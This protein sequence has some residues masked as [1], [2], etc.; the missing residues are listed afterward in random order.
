MADGDDIGAQQAAA[1][2]VTTAAGHAGRA[3]ESAGLARQGADRAGSA[4]AVAEAAAA[5][6]TGPPGPSYLLVISILGAALL[7]LIIGDLISLFTGNHSVDTNLMSVTTL[8]AGGL[9]GVL[10]PSPGK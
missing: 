3:A 6:I 8:I 2:A 4:A 9:I 7:A 1:E 10:A 5:R